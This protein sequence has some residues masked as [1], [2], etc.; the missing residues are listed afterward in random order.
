MN[1][2]NLYA[3]NPL[4]DAEVRRLLPLGAWLSDPK[5]K[6]ISL[7]NG[8]VR[9][10]WGGAGAM[11]NTGVSILGTAVRAAIRLLVAASGGYLDPETPFANLTLA[12]GARFHGALE[13][14]ANEPQISIRLH[15]GM[16]RPV[17]D[18]MTV[19]Q[20]HLLADA[21]VARKSVIVGGPTAAGKSTL[22]NAILELIPAD[23]R[24]IIIEDTFELH[25]AGATS[26]LMAMQCNTEAQLAVA[27]QTQLQR[28]LLMT[29][30]TTMAVASGEQLNEKSQVQAANAVNFNLGV[31]P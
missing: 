9:I 6:E 8:W 15:A 22:L 27:Q 4:I 13:P 11:R 26:V 30:I 3:P 20:A 16:G 24:L 25:N 31:M 14:V 17:G 10:D 21:I 7:N 2:P 19:P 28:Q 12:C 23:L 18:F 5:V 29:L 1:I